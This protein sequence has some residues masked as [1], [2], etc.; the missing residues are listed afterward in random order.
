MGVSML[1]L[2]VLRRAGTSLPSVSITLLQLFAIIAA[3]ESVSS[4]VVVE[5]LEVF[6]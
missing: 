1:T 3:E 2:S 5:A 4:A 6:M